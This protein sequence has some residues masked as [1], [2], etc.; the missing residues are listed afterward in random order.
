MLD[1]DT[2]CELAGSLPEVDEGTWYGAPAFRIRGKV[3]A[4]VHEN[5]P[6]LFLI[7]VGPGE[8]DALIS[9]EPGRFRG[10][11]HRPERHDSVLMSLA[12]TSPE[13]LTE[14]HELLRQAWR[15]IAPRK[16]VEQ[17]DA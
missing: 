3:F 15:R 8:R 6:D 13:Q 4:R 10:T 16:L 17:Q 5:D 14:V 1:V 9:A 11:E 7:K 12:A 2:M